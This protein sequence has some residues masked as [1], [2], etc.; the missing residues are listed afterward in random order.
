MLDI[1]M[2]I[3]ESIEIKGL[4]IT[5][6]SRLKYNID[7]EEFS[8]NISKKEMLSFVNSYEKKI[9]VMEKSIT[10]ADMREKTYK[11]VAKILH[12]DSEFGDEKSFKVLQEIKEFFWDYKG[13]PR[14]KVKQHYWSI[15]K[16]TANGVD[17]FDF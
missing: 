13:N 5:R 7:G 12:P 17:P 11:Q 1:K 14:E 8:E 4:L 2:E 6:I 10:I 9:V 3:G 16:D 15:E